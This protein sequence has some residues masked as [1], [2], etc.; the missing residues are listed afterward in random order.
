MTEERK[1]QLEQLRIEETQSTEQQQLAG[2]T[3]DG[4]RLISEGIAQAGRQRAA[5]PELVTVGKG[6]KKVSVRR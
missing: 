6:K 1:A 2:S 4:L 5:E 3:T